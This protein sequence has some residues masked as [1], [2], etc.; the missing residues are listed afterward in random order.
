[1]IAFQFNHNGQTFEAEF[2]RGQIEYDR[3]TVAAYLGLDPRQLPD[4]VSAAQA[5]VVIPPEKLSRFREWHSAAQETV[6]TLIKADN[7]YD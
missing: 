3:G 5:S 6:F 2:V 4:R 7:E 1:M